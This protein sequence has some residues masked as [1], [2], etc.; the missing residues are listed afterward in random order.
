MKMNPVCWFEI[1]VQDMDRATSFY[2]TVL[3]TNLSKLDSPTPDVEMMAFPMEMNVGGASGALVKMDGIEPGGGGTMV[4]F[5]CDDC[6][7]EESRIEAAGGKVEKSKM[8]I[9]EYGNMV[10]A[11]DTEGNLFGLH[12]HK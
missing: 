6:A 8:S 3:A 7:Q 10:L 11:I 12:S 1:Y 2:Q 9:G 5:D 4:Y